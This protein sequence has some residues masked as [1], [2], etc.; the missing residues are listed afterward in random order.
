MAPA[1]KKK[2]RSCK[3]LAAWFEEEEFK[4]VIKMNHPK[5]TENSVYC[6][7]C[8]KVINIDHQGRGDL[9]RYMEGVVHKKSLGSKRN[10]PRFSDIFIRKNDPI[11]R[12][13]QYAEVKVSGCLAKYNLPLATAD[14]LTHLFNDI[15]RVKLALTYSPCKLRQPS[16]QYWQVK[17]QFISYCI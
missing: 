6:L 5:N 14:H 1:G 2:R 13:V 15:D 11:E 12:H 7:V 4:G 8:E 17:A 10:Q 16:K 9:M 3:V